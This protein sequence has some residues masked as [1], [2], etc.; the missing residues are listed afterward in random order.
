MTGVLSFEAGAG[1]ELEVFGSLSGGFDE[2]SV[3]LLHGDT[4]EAGPITVYNAELVETKRAG[5]QAHDSR[6]LWASEFVVTGIHLPDQD[7]E[8]IGGFQ[9]ELSGLGGWSSEKPFSTGDSDASLDVRWNAPQPH[10][11]TA[12]GAAVSLTNV[13]R[14]SWR[15]EEVILRSVPC[16]QVALDAPVSVGSVIDEWVE[17]LR[18]LNNLVSD[19]ASRIESLELVA[20]SSGDGTVVMG[21]HP[22]VVRAVWPGSQGSGRRGPM[23]AIDLESSEVPFRD[24]IGRWMTLYA[25][26]KRSLSQF[27][28]EIDSP[29]ASPEIGFLRRV[30]VLEEYHRTWLPDVTVMSSDD[31]EALKVRLV[32]AAE[33]AG[34][35]NDV[36]WLKQ[37]LKRKLLNELSL[38]KRLRQLLNRCNGALQLIV[39]NEN[40]LSTQLADTRNFLAHGE[41]SLADRAIH[42]NDLVPAIELID[43]IVKALIWIDLGYRP[44]RVEHQLRRV[45]SFFDLS[46][47]L[48]A[49]TWIANPNSR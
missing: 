1:A 36:K 42:Q 10:V 4:P 37:Q 12:S 30:V 48:S 16:F 2:G 8:L 23:Y 21:Q 27:F 9:L 38:S 28:A 32:G 34:N 15:A 13:L 11:A 46:R 40:A 33:S 5:G 39:G 20:N 29:S 22:I 49:Y 35:P 26:Q 31:Y 45:H 6:Q 43:L 14:E 41:A 3:P 25:S 24:L 47:R 18:F 44:G 19:H 7:A 17:P